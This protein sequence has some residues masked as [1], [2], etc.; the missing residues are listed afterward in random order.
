MTAT[1]W[2]VLLAMFV[3]STAE[4]GCRRGDGD[5]ERPVSR[6][7]KPAPASLEELAREVGLAFPASAR[8]VGFNRENGMDD[9]LQFKV[10]IDAR[11]L[12]A[13]RA[14][15]PIPEEAMKAGERGLLGPDQG[16]WDPNRARNLRTGQKS[17]P[18]ARALNIGLAERGAKVCLY[19][20]NHGT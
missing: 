11:D 9:Y 6:E 4:G 7:T 12:P 10:E 8:L 16:F 13:F 3:L 5:Q 17:L 14:S 20:V 15:S 2:F 1:A 18:N 19:I